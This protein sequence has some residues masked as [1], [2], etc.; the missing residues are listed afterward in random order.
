MAGQPCERASSPPEPGCRSGG[1]PRSSRKYKRY[2]RILYESSKDTDG[3]S[4][5]AE[6]LATRTHCRGLTHYCSSTRRSRS[7]AVTALTFKAAVLKRFI[8]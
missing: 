8:S 7:A 1:G 4:H 3:D 5:R 2:V 6:G